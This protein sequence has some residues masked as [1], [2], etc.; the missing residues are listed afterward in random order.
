MLLFVYSYFRSIFVYGDWLI[1]F[2]YVIKKNWTR[3]KIG[4]S[5]GAKI[6]VPSWPRKNFVLTLFV[7]LTPGLHYF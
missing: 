4:G 3:T 6:L 2:V 7:L 1:Y 5:P